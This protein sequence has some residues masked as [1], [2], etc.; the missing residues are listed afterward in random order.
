M[1]QSSAALVLECSPLRPRGQGESVLR[2]FAF[3]TRR[4]RE[5]FAPVEIG[6]RKPPVSTWQAGAAWDAER[7]A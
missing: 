1:L 2:G 6:T 5:R 3:S 4:G 7:R